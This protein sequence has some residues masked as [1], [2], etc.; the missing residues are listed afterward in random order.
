[1]YAVAPPTCMLVH[2]INP[3][4]LSALVQE[5]NRQLAEDESVAALLPIDPPEQVRI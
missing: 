3:S 1:M 2:V 4:E 5:I